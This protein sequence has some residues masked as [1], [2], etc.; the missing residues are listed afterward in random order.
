MEEKRRTGAVRRRRGEGIIGRKSVQR[1]FTDLRA[2]DKNPINN[3]V[4]YLLDGKKKRGGGKENK[5]A[6]GTMV[7]KV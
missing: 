2:G 6:S 3:L 4:S 1:T 5:E 7:F